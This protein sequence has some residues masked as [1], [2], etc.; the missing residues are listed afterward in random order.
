M[1][2]AKNYAAQ[3]ERGLLEW[4]GSVSKEYPRDALR[5]MDLSVAIGRSV[6]FA[7]PDGGK[8]LNGNL[9][10]MRGVDFRLPF[11]EITVEYS[12]QEVGVRRLVYAR[13]LGP[14]EITGPDGGVTI[15]AL[16]FSGGQW[17]PD[18][19]FAIVN[20]KW[21]DPSLS[22]HRRL[23]FQGPADFTI[24]KLGEDGAEKCLTT[25]VGWD[26]TVVL[27]LC[28]ALSCSNVEKELIETIDTRKNERRIKQGKLPLY[29]TYQ[30]VIKAPGSSA[31]KVAGIQGGA[32][33]R[34]GP[35]EHL[36][37]G[38]IRRLSDDKKVWVQSCVVGARSKGVIDKSYAVA[39]A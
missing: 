13:D 29:E 33:D 34:N 12:F 3:A 35:R 1:I 22:L 5:A 26:A 4:A 14:N 6:H 37:R 20:R 36:R 11:P 15:V 32:H 24:K 38:H 31:R 18:G 39:C 28:E 9:R 2:T 25:A 17:V 21:D 30:L 8:I 10:G 19:M 16:S 7:M 23:A 27:E